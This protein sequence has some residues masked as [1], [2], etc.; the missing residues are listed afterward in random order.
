MPTTHGEARI[1]SSPPVRA[2]NAAPNNVSLS[3]GTTSA[4]PANVLEMAGQL[5]EPPTPIAANA[6]EKQTGKTT[7]RVPEATKKKQPS[8][9][10]SYLRSLV[11]EKF[12]PKIDTEGIIYQTKQA[13]VRG[14]QAKKVRVEL[15]ESDIQNLISTRFPSAPQYVI[16]NPEIRALEIKGDS[17]WTPST[18][19][20]AVECFYIPS[21]TRVVIIW[22]DLFDRPVLRK[23]KEYQKGSRV[24]TPCPYCG[25]N[26]YVKFLCFTVQKKPQRPRHTVNLDALCSPCI[27]PIMECSSPS[28]YGEKPTK[29]AKLDS[30][31]EVAE[32]QSA[33]SFTIAT[34]KCFERYPES[35]RR[36][37]N[38]FVSGI[39][40]NTDG[41]TFASRALIY[42]ILDD[43]NSFSTVAARLQRNYEENW[44]ASREAYI[45]FVIE[46][47]KPAAN[48]GIARYFA[49][50]GTTTAA[51]S[52]IWPDLRKDEFAVENSPPKED[53]IETLF[54]IVFEEVRPFLLRDLY[55]R[56]PTP[57]IAWDGTYKLA[58]L[59]IN[60]ILSE[61][62]QNVLLVIYDQYGRVLNYGFG[63][64]EQPLHWQRLHYLL[65][66]RCEK[67]GPQ[68]VN[69]VRF[70]Y[71]DLCCEGLNDRADHWFVKM[72]PS[73]LTAPLKDMFHAH[74]MVT[75]PGSVRGSG[76]DL[77]ANFC[78]D[79]SAATLQFTEESIRLAVAQYC[80]Q[81]PEV[82][83]DRARESV[84]LE[85]SWR[86][87]MYNFTTPTAEAASKCRALWAKL[88]VDEE[89]LRQETE[90]SNKQYQYYILTPIADKRRGGDWEMQ[91]FIRHLEKG[92]YE[93]P[94]PPE[95]MSYPLKESSDGSL[96]D[97]GR[98]RGTSGGEAS[99]KQMNSASNKAT[100][101]SPRL[102][103][104]K[105]LLRITRLN[106]DKDERFESVTGVKAKSPF[107]YLDEAMEQRASQCEYT[108]I[109]VSS[110]YPASID[111]YDEPVGIEFS[112]QKDWSSIDQYLFFHELVDHD[113]MDLHRG[114]RGAA[115]GTLQSTAGFSAGNTVWNRKEGGQAR[116]PLNKF[117]V[118]E[119]LTAVQEQHLADICV[120]IQRNHSSKIN[121]LNSYAK[122]VKSIWD[123]HHYS[124][125]TKGLPGM[126]G[127]MPLDLAKSRIKQ[128]TDTAVASRAGPSSF[129]SMFV[130]GAM[131]DPLQ[132]Y[133]VPVQTGGMAMMPTSDVG[134][135]SRPVVPVLPASGQLLSP[136]IFQLP[137]TSTYTAQ[138]ILGKKR[139]RPKKEV[140]S[141]E[142]LEQL[143]LERAHALSHRQL[144]HYTKQ[145]N[146][147]SPR[148]KAKALRVVVNYIRERQES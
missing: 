105:L 97:L 144:R 41:T 80:A 147:T 22:P 114:D 37:Y 78:R 146:G 112:R 65:R 59:T 69:H 50:P 74:K 14:T 6:E 101:L 70:G 43:R 11:S 129:E 18:V 57:I 83:P 102:S 116:T 54:Y 47:G 21:G 104:A 132:P 137:P 13:G 42:E 123:Q 139:G 88:K 124:Q 99:N 35:V 142:P 38:R 148:D 138:P 31:S 128:M 56:L 119:K 62:E 25:S 90:K 108:S 141:P 67:H 2:S 135:L 8:K 125:L 23:H 85:K 143:S 71:S 1:N 58:G 3:D 89:K 10:T 96:V 66:K 4:T 140:H 100:R 73:V 40:T 127:V 61:E 20:E 15:S 134:G 39:G 77:H 131:Q 95:R 109:K 64:T 93:D 92:C 72:W 118:K 52:V 49:Q 91:N 115:Q 7:S 103:D 130:L 126:G 55:S 5:K 26:E 117:V 122:M 27:S 45:D 76:H 34:R 94:L 44:T 120:N 46:H 12:F 17:Q 111:G 106:R 36:R 32:L 53:A 19:K 113:M 82:L 24:L 145:I 84:M 81:N 107:W 60:D 75:G 68:H 33:H 30:W 28:C 79:L 48:A 29:G 121:T 110:E 87:K 86:K 136:Q 16:P 51:A 98:F 133:V 9:I 63:D